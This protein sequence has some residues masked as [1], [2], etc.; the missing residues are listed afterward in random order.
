[1]IVLVSLGTMNTELPKPP[2]LAPCLGIRFNCFMLLG[3]GSR[4]EY[5]NIKLHYQV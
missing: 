2:G 3:Q 5:L 1:M 4:R